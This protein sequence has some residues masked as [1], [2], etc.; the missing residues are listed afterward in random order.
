MSAESVNATTQ[1]PRQFNELE[2]LGF[3]LLKYIKSKYPLQDG[4]NFA[5]IHD[6]VINEI[7]DIKRKGSKIFVTKH[8]VSRRAPAPAVPA[9]ASLLN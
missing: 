8:K 9:P 5:T 2:E 7:F 3:V 6:K 4:V 1:A